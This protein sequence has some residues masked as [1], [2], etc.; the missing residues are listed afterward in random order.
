M[1]KSEEQFRRLEEILRVNPLIIGIGNE[2]RGD[3]GAGIALVRRISRNGYSPTL[4]VYANPENYLRRIA[5]IPHRVRLWTDI[6][7]FGGNPGD[8]RILSPEEIDRVAISTHNFSLTVL[9]RY[10]QESHP[11][12]EFLL[13]IQPRS[14]ALGEP[15]TPEVQHIVDVLADFISRINEAGGSIRE[16]RT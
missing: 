3:D 15:L 5:A 6:V 11:A 16:E 1:E 2:L 13:G 7:H 12:R 10:L 9:F 4:L 8:F 14:T